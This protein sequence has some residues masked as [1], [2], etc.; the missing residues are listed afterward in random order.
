MPRINLLPWRSEERQR[1]K[2]QFQLAVVA[3]VSAGFLVA[4]L[5]SLVVGGMISSQRERNAFLRAQIAALDGDINEIRG[6]QTQK[7]RLLARMA[8]IERLQRSRP[9]IV[10]VFDQL[11]HTLPDGVYLTSVHQ[12]GRKLE[13]KGIA[14]SSTR[15]STFM[16]NIEGSEWIGSPELQL[17]ETKSGTGAGGAEFVLTAMQKGLE[18]ETDILPGTRKRRAGP[19]TEVAP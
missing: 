18:P 4:F 11:M 2:R 5:G 12:I 7:Q 1:R 17:I 8:I 19:R 9:E 6:L 13:V 16:R 3:A 10:H 14:Q 15:V